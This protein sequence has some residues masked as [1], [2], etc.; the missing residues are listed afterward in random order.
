MA[1][2]SIALAWKVSVGATLPWVRIPLSPPIIM[3]IIKLPI[4]R[5]VIPSIVRRYKILTNPIIKN[6]DFKGL[7]IDLDLRESLERKIYFNNEYEEERINFLK[8]KSQENSC[9]IF[10]DIGA[11]IGIYTLSF[12]QTEKKISNFIAF[13]PLES[14]F[15][16]LKSN[17]DKNNLKEKVTLFKYGLSSKS[18]SLY[19]SLVQ[20]GNLLQSAGFKINHNGD[21]KIKVKVGDEL[22]IFKNK[23]IVIKCDV[24]GHELEALK[25]IKK[26]LTNN[27]CILQIE[28]WDHNKNEL[29]NFLGK[30]NYKFIKKIVGDYYFI[31]MNL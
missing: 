17:L 8:I 4:L 15:K 11:N 1:E 24:E 19:G 5:R 14:N 20:K 3:K 13:E 22:L 28:I 2:W 21:T 30:I 27:N 18:A 7:K 31:K 10:I 16:K 9:S 23:N 6:Y 26:L 12:C 25:G 29:Y